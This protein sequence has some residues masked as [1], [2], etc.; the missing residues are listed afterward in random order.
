MDTTEPCVF[1]EIS[2][3]RRWTLF[4]TSALRDDLALDRSREECWPL[5]GEGEVPNTFLM[6]MTAWRRRP[7][8]R[9]TRRS[10]IERQTGEPVSKG[11][12][13]T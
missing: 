10:A 9:G 7:L 6:S 11:K 2:S 8:R 13:D 4:S 12:N 5:F 1:A 3:L